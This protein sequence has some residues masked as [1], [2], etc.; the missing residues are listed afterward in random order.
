MM[1]VCHPVSQALI[2]Q[3]PKAERLVAE[4]RA[5]EALQDCGGGRTLP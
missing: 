3:D 2:A 1:L 4:A 5:A